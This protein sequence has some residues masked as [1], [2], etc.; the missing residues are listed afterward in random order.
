MKLVVMAIA[1][2]TVA[3][4]LWVARE[5][6]HR[7]PPTAYFALPFVF[8]YPFMFGFVNFALSM[9]LAFLAFGLWLRLARF[10]HSGCA[11]FC[12]CRSLSSSFS[13]TPTAGGC[14]ACCA[15]S[16]EAVR[17][18]D[19]GR[20]WW[21]AG[22]RRDP[23][24]AVMALPL[25]IIL[26]WR[27]DISQDDDP[28]LVQLVDKWLWIESALRDRWKPFDIGMLI[29]RGHRL[30]VGDLQQAP[31]IFAQSLVLGAGAWQSRS[32]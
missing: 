13:L 19:A 27:S 11:P 12:S 1:P 21:R 32:S 24:A 17:Q 9:A 31:A 20:S 3:G 22:T 25:I 6:H 30:S 2:L 18:H 8:G 26:A 23:P 29:R 4:F 5:V 10:G 28:R 7:V 14:S 15:F 16:A